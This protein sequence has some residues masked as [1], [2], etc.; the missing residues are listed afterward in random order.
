MPVKLLIKS[1]K[2]EIRI[3]RA[4]T[5]VEDASEDED[6]VDKGEQHE[7]FVSKNNSMVQEPY[8]TKG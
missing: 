5:D 3:C 4:H 8:E 6:D 7:E 1:L 2:C